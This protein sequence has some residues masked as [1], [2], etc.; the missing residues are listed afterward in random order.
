MCDICVYGIWH[1]IFYSSSILFYF[2]PLCVCVGFLIQIFLW[3]MKSFGPHTFHNPKTAGVSYENHIQ[4][5]RTALNQQLKRYHHIQMGN[6]YL[7]AQPYAV[8]FSM[9][10][11][12]SMMNFSIQK[13]NLI[14]FGKLKDN[15]LRAPL[16]F[17]CILSSI[18]MSY[19]W[20][21]SPFSFLLYCFWTIFILIVKIHWTWNSSLCFFFSLNSNQSG[22]CLQPVVLKELNCKLHSCHGLNTKR[23]TTH[24][25]SNNKRGEKN[26]N[27]TV[28]TSKSI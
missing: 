1:P 10:L 19:N 8:W 14:I 6:Y 18:F 4:K 13:L 9:Y 16:N 22:V 23:R 7:P 25:H 27:F 3:D 15:I 5:K 28:I 11:F 20:M 26:Y 12:A 17:C 24:Q 21:G 2:F